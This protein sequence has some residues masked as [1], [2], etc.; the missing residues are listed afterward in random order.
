SPSPTQS[1]ARAHTHHTHSHTL[2]TLHTLNCLTTTWDRHTPTAAATTT[3]TTT[4]RSIHRQRRWLRDIPRKHQRAHIEAGGEV[5]GPA[6]LDFGH[7]GAR[8]T[9]IWQATIASSETMTLVVMP[10]GSH[11]VQPH[12]QQQERH[13]QPNH[14]Q[15]QHK[16]QQQRQQEQRHT[17]R[18]TPHPPHPAPSHSRPPSVWPPSQP[19]SQARR[20]RRIDGAAFLHHHDRS[21]RFTVHSAPVHP[22]LPL[23]LLL[24]LTTLTALLLPSPTAAYDF[25]PG[26]DGAVQWAYGCDFLDL[27]ADPIVHS[28]ADPGWHCGL[29]CVQYAGCTHFAWQNRTATSGRCFLHTAASAYFVDNSGSGAFCGYTVVGFTILP[30]PA[31]VPTATLA[32]PEP[33]TTV[34]QVET[35]VAQNPG[36]NVPVTSTATGVE[37]GQG[38][39]GD[40]N[41]GSGGSTGSAASSATAESSV[42]LT[43]SNG[44]T[45]MGPPPKS[46][47]SSGGAGGSNGGSGS[48][49]NNNNSNPTSGGSP[50]LGGSTSTSS[51][52]PLALILAIAAAVLSAAALGVGV[53]L[54]LRQRRLRRAG[55]G[56]PDRKAYRVSIASS[57]ESNIFRT[58]SSAPATAGSGASTAQRSSSASA[59]A[60]TPTSTGS[61]AR[62][63]A[64]PDEGGASGAAAAAAGRRSL[65]VTTPSTRSFGVLSA[66]SV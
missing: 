29:A 20:S 31:V 54:L 39:G 23:L 50:P 53:A 7:F 61:L 15:Y 36:A 35:S 37:A 46:T 2:H 47:T 4:P 43:V 10:T 28:V 18:T 8:A 24:V 9:R 45:I 58:S 13:G 49:N 62:S 65:S 64:S 11:L 56:G 3:T 27:P 66:T 33:S 34:A 57:V 14:A 38:G 6:T 41:G 21:A 44:I 32:P 5:R 17:A 48:A 42:V 60:S 25:Q 16:Q 40:G 63:L 52:P 26:N 30:K 19:L 1:L 51:S 22:L 59:S 12:Q 55:D